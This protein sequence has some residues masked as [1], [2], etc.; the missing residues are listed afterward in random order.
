[1]KSQE[2]PD[3]LDMHSQ[4][5]EMWIKCLVKAKKGVF[6]DKSQSLSQLL[7]R[8][9]PNPGTAA[10]LSIHFNPKFSLKSCINTYSMDCGFWGASCRLGLK[11]QHPPS[12]DLA[13][14]IPFKI[15]V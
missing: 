9:F 5:E 13:L 15:H 10:E 11:I 1:M 14:N 4:G 7:S 3:V 6:K 8:I 12:Q 2:G